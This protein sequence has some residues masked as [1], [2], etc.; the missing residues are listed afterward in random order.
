[1]SMTTQQ[2]VARTGTVGFVVATVALSVAF[3]AVAL[4]LHVL[5]LIAP[6]GAVCYGD[7]SCP[8]AVLEVSMYGSIGVPVIL[9][10]AVVVLS[11]RARHRARRVA[12]WWF[13]GT[14]ALV[15]FSIVNTIV[16]IE[17][18]SSHALAR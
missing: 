18:M 4:F 10:V 8:E 12:P 14:C 16:R 2:S 11:V 17:A 9:L 13:G 1:M 6:M 7:E 3:A 5:Y 15:V